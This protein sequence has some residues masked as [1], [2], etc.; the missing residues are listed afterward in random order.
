MDSLRVL[1]KDLQI[2]SLFF[3][4]AHALGKEYS[5]NR[6]VQDSRVSKRTHQICRMSEEDKSE[7]FV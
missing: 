7:K 4:K 3:L 6:Y 1:I 2:F 5:Q